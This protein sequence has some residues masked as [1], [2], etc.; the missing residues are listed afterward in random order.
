MPQTPNPNQ[1]KLDRIAVMS[2]GFG[3][4]LK[5]TARPGNPSA[6]VDILDLAAMVAERY[7]IRR[8]EF[9]HTDFPSTEDAY[10]LELRSRVQKANSQ[11]NQI[12]LEFANLN[13]S[14]PDPVIRL[15]TI[16]LTKKWIDYAAAIGCPRVMLNQGEIKPEVRQSAIDTLKTINAYGKA[17]KVF[18]TMENRGGPWEP[19][20]DIIKASGI[21]ANPDCGNFPDKAAQAAGL[22]VMYKMTSGSSHVKHNPAKFD[23]ADAVRIAKEAGYTGI[24]T[25]E[26]SSRGATDPYA[27]VQTMRDILLANL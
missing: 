15:E 2:G 20:V 10:L 16:D 3:P 19:V 25:I 17:K 26:A 13:V 27:P 24:F 14:T 9:Q 22:A 1:A 11:V 7:G 5:G 12:N 8:I 18:V 21:W 4:L 6:T 23:I